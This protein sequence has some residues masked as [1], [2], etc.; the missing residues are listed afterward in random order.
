MNQA[1]LERVPGLGE[2]IKRISPLGRVVTT[3]EVADYIV[4]LCSP[5][6]SYINGSHLIID[7]GI[8]L[9]ANVA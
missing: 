3:E 2:A 1:S 5:S 8:S 6:A 9:T 4:F 7:A